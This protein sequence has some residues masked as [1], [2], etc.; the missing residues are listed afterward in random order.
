MSL[1]RHVLRHHRG[2]ILN[3]PIIDTSAGWPLYKRGFNYRVTTVD[4]CPENSTKIG[5]VGMIKLISVVLHNV[6]LFSWLLAKTNYLSKTVVLSPFL[7]VW[8]LYRRH[9]SRSGTLPHCTLAFWL[10]IYLFVPLL[11]RN[12]RDPNIQPFHRQKLKSFIKYSWNPL[13]ADC[14]VGNYWTRYDQGRKNVSNW[15]VTTVLFSN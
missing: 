8:K 3:F 2:K 13:I 14:K 12:R 7:F 9:Y 15:R 11:H 5:Q 10:P 6:T 4:T 1:F